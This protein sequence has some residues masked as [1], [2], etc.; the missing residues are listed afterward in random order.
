LLSLIA[1]PI[2]LSTATMR[3]DVSRSSNFVGR[4]ITQSLAAPKTSC[5]CHRPCAVIPSSPEDR[6]RYSLEQPAIAQVERLGGSVKRE[7]IGSKLFVTEVDMVFHYTQDGHRVENKTFTEEALPHIANF[8]HLRTLVLSGG[9]ITDDGLRRLAELKELKC[10]ILRDARLVSRAGVAPL[11]KLPQLRRLELT[12][13]PIGDAGFAQLAAVQSLEDL[14]VTGSGLSDESLA[15]ASRL[16]NLTNLSLD[17]GNRAIGREALLGLHALP[18]LKRLSLRCSEITDEALAQ[19]AS[20]TNLRLLS[21]G[22]SR[23]S[24]RGLASLRRSLPDL[25][26]QTT[27]QSLRW[28]PA[29]PWEQ[30]RGDTPCPQE[31]V[32]LG[33][34]LL[35][36]IRGRA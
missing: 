12:N 21:L 30:S 23:V 1:L 36:V 26:V 25:A 13:A 17:L 24:R 29:F 8:H 10:L 22:D 31:V 9:Q 34:F 11:V 3:P 6:I 28:R 19:V 5:C 32:A 16:R 14:S 20:L 35:N 33:R 27:Q 2:L 4:S 18:N 7:Q 15:V